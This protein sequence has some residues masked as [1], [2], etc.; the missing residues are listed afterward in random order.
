MK[1]IK[2]LLIAVVAVIIIC[3]LGTVTAV[4]YFN[5]EKF[6]KQELESELNA[7]AHSTADE[8]GGWVNTRKTE[9]EMLAN[10]PV[11]ASGDKQAIINYL[12][13]E[14]KRLGNFNAMWVSDPAGNWYSPVGTSGSIKERTYYTELMTS[15]KTV[16]SDPLIGKADGKMT[17]VIAV[18]IKVNGQVAGILGGNVS[19]EEFIRIVNDIKIGQTGHAAVFAS[20]G[21]TVV[22]PDR[23]KIMKYNPMTDDALGAGLKEAYAAAGQGNAGIRG[24]S[25]EG[26][27]KYLS[28]TPIP[29]LKWTVTTT[30]AVQ[31]FTGPLRGLFV[32]SAVTAIIIFLISLLVVIVVSGKMTRPLAVLREAAEKVAQ[33]DLN[34]HIELKNQ[35]EL[36][37]LARSFALM[38]QNLRDLIGKVILS[39]QTLTASSE[40]LT[41]HAQQ[42]AQ[43]AG[44]MS[45]TIT[46]VAGDSSK[47]LQATGAMLHTMEEMSGRMVQA[48]G[49]AGHIVAT[50]EKT[51]AAAYT[52]GQAVA[53]VVAQMA[54]IE[55]TVTGSAEAVRMLGE[56]SQ[57]IGQIVDTISGIAGQTNLLALNAAV[58]A[59]RAGELGRGFAVVAEEVR[60][61]AEQSH[62]AAMQ[63]AGLIGSIQN[64]TRT[65]VAAMDEGT[66][67]V[68]KG[69]EVVQ[70][71]GSAF[72]DIAVMINGMSDQI[73]NVAGV[74]EQVADDSKQIVGSVREF[75]GTSEHTAAEVQSVSAGTQE[76]SASSQEIAASSQK[77]AELA[78]EL[79]NS[80]KLFK[81]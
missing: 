12:G 77:L 34:I 61:L 9:M 69:S 20:D 16:I 28:Y 7:T 19:M 57:E 56:R 52:G 6:I 81:L 33:G 67:E 32:S 62:E 10:S 22:H 30:A 53:S 71:A 13:T 38:V 8:L 59:A 65:A 58:E 48:S 5:I 76:Q 54:A 80:V 66:Q 78:E 70:T 50:S 15:G 29:G 35:N 40:Q 46:G 41:A 60:Q 26:A 24:F 17:F 68:R 49:N 39:A 1:S 23:D 11:L 37:V 72:A 25:E 75:A 74:V 3:S 21:T 18:P 47:Q 63:I 44:K 43:A 27:E 4:N 64:D 55:K 51:A 45:Q 14:N 42:S 36:G 73:K 79:Q 2:T 31:E